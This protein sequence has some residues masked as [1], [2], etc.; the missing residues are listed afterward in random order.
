MG[1][2][3]V[4]FPEEEEGIMRVAMSPDIIIRWPSMLPTYIWGALDE[5]AEE[6]KNFISLSCHVYVMREQTLFA[7]ALTSVYVVYFVYMSWNVMSRVE[8]IALMEAAQIADER[9][10]AQA[11]FVVY[12]PPP[13]NCTLGEIYGNASLEPPELLACIAEDRVEVF[14][15]T[16]PWIPIMFIVL[17][18]LQQARHE[19]LHKN[20]AITGVAKTLDSLVWS[21]RGV[22]KGLVLI[23][24][25]G[26]DRVIHPVK[27]D[28]DSYRRGD[29]TSE[30][31]CLK[32]QAK[33]YGPIEQ[34]KEYRNLGWFKRANARLLYLYYEPCRYYLSFER[35][36]AEPPEL[37]DE[38]EEVVETASTAS[39]HYTDVRKTTEEELIEEFLGKLEDPPLAPPPASF[40]EGLAVMYS[41]F[42]AK[43]QRGMNREEKDK[44]SKGRALKAL[45]AA[46]QL[47]CKAEDYAPHQTAATL[48]E[49]SLRSAF[50][51]VL[52]AWRIR[53]PQ[54]KVGDAILVPRDFAVVRRACDQAKFDVD[55]RWSRMPNTAGRFGTVTR[56]EL[57]VGV[58]LCPAVYFADPI[59]ETFLFPPRLLRVVRPGQPVRVIASKDRLEE[60]FE[61]RGWRMTE[62]LLATCGHVGALERLYGGQ[63]DGQ[64]TG[65]T[66]LVSFGGAVGSSFAYPPDA[67]VFLTERPPAEK[68]A[69]ALEDAFPPPP[70]EL[71]QELAD[72]PQEGNTSGFIDGPG[73]PDA[74][75]AA[76]LDL[77]ARLDAE[78]A[79]IEKDEA[80]VA[81]LG[82]P[83]TD[84]I[85]GLSVIPDGIIVFAPPEKPVGGDLGAFENLDARIYDKMRALE[86]VVNPF[87]RRK[88][89]EDAPFEPGAT[90]VMIE[91]PP[92]E[93]LALA[94]IPLRSF[95]RHTEAALGVRC[96]GRALSKDELPPPPPTTDDKKADRERNR[97]RMVRAAK[98][99]G[100]A[101]AI[102]QKTDDALRT[103]L[104]R[105]CIKGNDNAVNAIILAPG[106][107]VTT[108]ARDRDGMT[109]LH[110]ACFRGHIEVVQKLMAMELRE[111]L[112]Q[113]DYV[114]SENFMSALH[115]A[116]LGGSVPVVEQLL[117]LEQFEDFPEELEEL[118]AADAKGRSPLHLAAHKG[119]AGAA[120][121]L[122]EKGPKD[123]AT[124][125]DPR[126]RSPLHYAA[127]RGHLACVQVFLE[128]LSRGKEL[129]FLQDE[130]ECTPLD[131]AEESAVDNEEIEEVIATLKKFKK[132]NIAAEQVSA[133]Q[134]LQE[135]D[136]DDDLLAQLN[137]EAGN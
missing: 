33:L 11:E 53:C 95:C 134:L 62:G 20:F 54:I 115:W 46:R 16:L 103:Q 123:L 18:L 135:S 5:L 72:A 47:L 120:A 26:A 32:V 89:Q 21:I 132:K 121:A 84:E 27:V 88:E 44:A 108:W 90:T 130:D 131:L 65:M 9:E 99:S 126:G 109:P 124:R 78:E 50:S 70:G 58:G 119:K 87:D 127:L 104:H 105:A 13:Q 7:L 1:A 24:V 15:W 96:D 39:S 36:I 28:L 100:G 6:W 8:M 107:L 116:A 106:G 68:S 73:P 133:A 117:T 57:S 71:P 10:R 56:T 49:N 112:G 12:A 113:L 86:D 60:V 29:D 110:W 35:G 81:A 19:Y 14:L 118:L 34:E 92:L 42:D 17:F 25:K 98:A 37:E 114:D 101:G 63:D 69:P 48:L 55:W 4:K 31:Y 38:E 23:D 30:W 59:D 137:A 22:F 129:A 41:E 66:A 77:A 2:K 136:S 52:D 61:A 111:K 125:L 85:A 93:F 102:L 43:P 51:R 128:P 40:T 94:S 75:P 91:V 45:R 64:G 74:L 3:P 79:K 76:P 80:E 67:V 122:L 82:I 83:G 97:V